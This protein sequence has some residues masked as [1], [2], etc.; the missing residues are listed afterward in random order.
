[1][2]IEIITPATREEWLALRRQTIGASEI[3]ALL[4]VHPWL[5]AYSLFATKS[6]LL[7][8]DHDESP[9]QRRGRLLEDDALALLQEERPDWS[10]VPNPMPGGRFFRNMATRESCTPDALAKDPLRNGFG[11]IQIKSVEPSIFRRKWRAEDGTVEPPIWIAVQALVEANLTG[12]SW[13]VVAALRV[14]F[15]LDIDVIDI[16]LHSGLIARLEQEVAAFW[17]AVESGQPP[18]A[19]YA[20]DGDV[21]AA[22]YEPT[23]EVIDLSSDNY[24]MELAD[25]RARLSAGKTAAD[26]RM[27]EIKAELLTKLNGASAARLADGRMLEAKRVK[28][29]GYTVADSEYLDLRVK[30][31]KADA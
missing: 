31:G 9:A 22:M 4:G 7:S 14:G 17:R 29:K 18:A 15:G 13:A 8:T 28:R 24:A 1:M 12:A 10:V 11:V 23:G 27:S 16:P 26:K 20:R 6:G 19:D 2:S 5:T 25:E 30:K 3:A 21:I